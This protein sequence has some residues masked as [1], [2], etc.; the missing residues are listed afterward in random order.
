MAISPSEGNRGGKYF[1]LNVVAFLKD[2]KSDSGTSS[3]LVVK[4][5]ADCVRVDVARPVIRITA[6]VTAY[7]LRTRGCQFEFWVLRTSRPKRSK[8][9]KT[10]CPRTV[11]TIRKL[12]QG[13]RLAWLKVSRSLSG[14]GDRAI[15]FHLSWEM[16]SLTGQTAAARQI[17][18][19]KAT[20]TLIVKPVGQSGTGSPSRQW[21]TMMMATSMATLRTHHKISGHHCESC[22]LMR[23]GL[24]FPGPGSLSS[25]TNWTFLSCSDKN[26]SLPSCTRPEAPSDLT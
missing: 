1:C 6:A 14:R 3:S 17:V 18:A 22:H 4:T 12:P 7:I 15:Q 5:M 19:N 10:H 13:P 2:T 26:G 16:P 25:S 24:S 21:R 20:T 8:Y 11:K 23:R 9:R